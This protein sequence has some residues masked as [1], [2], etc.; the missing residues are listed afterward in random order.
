MSAFDKCSLGGVAD[1]LGESEQTVSRGMQ[2]TFATV[3]GG[4]ASKSD[5]SSLLRKILSGHGA[6]GNK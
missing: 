3:L 2:S 4:M 5:N 1:A 6:V